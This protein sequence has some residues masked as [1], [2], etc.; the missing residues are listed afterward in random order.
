MNKLG[1]NR[2]FVYQ[3]ASCN[4]NFNE[5][6][7]ITSDD[8]KAQLRDELDVDDRVLFQRP[9]LHIAQNFTSMVTPA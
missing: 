2:E 6:F 7:L 9:L 1:P 4:T 8:K 5:I 3:H